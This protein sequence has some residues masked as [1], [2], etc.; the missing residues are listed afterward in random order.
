MPNRGAPRL[1]LP[2]LVL[3]ALLGGGCSSAPKGPAEVTTQRK[4]AESQLDQANKDADRGEYEKALEALENVWQ[5]AVRID[6]PP[7]RIRTNLARGK[8][9]L[10]LNRREEAGAAWE[11]ALAE[12]EWEG[13]RDLAARSRLYQAQQRL[14]QGEGPGKIREAALKELAAV[15]DGPTRA[16]GFTVLGL[17]EKEM[18]QWEPAEK[19]FKNALEIHEKA[20]NLESAAYDWYLIASVR[21][22]AGFYAAAREALWQAIGLDRRAENTY[23]LGMDWRALGEVFEKEGNAA[24][25]S[26]ARRRSSAVNSSGFAFLMAC[27]V[28]SSALAGSRSR[29]SARIANRTC[30]NAPLSPRRAMSVQTALASSVRPQRR[31]R[32]ASRVCASPDSA[33]AAAA[34]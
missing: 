12:A 9:L 19:A 2:A 33:P 3:S 23:G 1:L 34:W 4:L 15:K 13:E 28:S 5:T 30:G 29:C 24:E 7:L 18:R 14:F 8:A 20:Q 27:Q 25:A 31:C 17:A 16:L 21:S 26:R 10:Y 22:V 6:S 32:S 11:E